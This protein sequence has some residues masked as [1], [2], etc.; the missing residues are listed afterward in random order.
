LDEVAQWRVPVANSKQHLEFWHEHLENFRALQRSHREKMPSIKSRI[1]RM[2]DSETAGEEIWMWIDEYENQ[3]SY[4]RMSKALHED[5]E[6]SK[7]RQ[8]ASSRFNALLVPGS[9]KTEVW[10]EHFRLD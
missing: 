9:R 6:L 2:N 4:D 5:P 1:L 10:T 7:F 8:Q 3:E